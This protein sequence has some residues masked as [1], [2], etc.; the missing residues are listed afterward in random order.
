MYY[1]KSG[2]V[3]DRRLTTSNS[4]LVSKTF[5]QRTTEL[6]LYFFSRSFCT[7]TVIIPSFLLLPP[8]KISVGVKRKG[9][10]RKATKNGEGVGL[11]QTS[12]RS[13]TTAETIS[14]RKRERVRNDGGLRRPQKSFVDRL[15][16]RDSTRQRIF[17]DR[18]VDVSPLK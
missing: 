11:T 10:S 5:R 6:L 13:R 12:R 4:T 7:Y 14:G 2:R 16:L 17:Q 8:N 15:L 1:H 3:C 18:T 9:E